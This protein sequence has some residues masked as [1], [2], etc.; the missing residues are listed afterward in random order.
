MLTD[1]VGS[2]TQISP[3]SPEFGYLEYG[4]QLA[5]NASTARIVSAFAVSNPHLS[6]QFESRCRVN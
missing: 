1:K 2:K 5:L 3:S 6:L 4:L